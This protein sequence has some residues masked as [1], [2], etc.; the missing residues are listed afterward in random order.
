ACGVL[1]IDVDRFKPLNDYY[2]HAAGDA[3]L[4]EV[5]ARLRE[6]V[7][8]SD[9]VAR[10]GGEEFLVV[11]SGAGAEETAVIAERLRAAIADRPIDLGQAK[12]PVTVSIG[13]ALSGLTTEAETL[14]AAA[15]SAMYRAKGSGRNCVEAASEVDWRPV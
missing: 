9:I 6:H 14:I 4:R 1:M 11:M 2:G 10:Y 12:L 8:A 3:A 13:S 15:D 7:R 5:A